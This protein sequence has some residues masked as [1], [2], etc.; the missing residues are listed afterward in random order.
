MSCAPRVILI[1]PSPATRDVLARRLRAQGFDVD[2]TGDPAA[3]ADMALCAPPKAVIADLWMGGVSGVQL[4]RL[5]RA[6]PAT[7]EIAVLLRGDTDEPR[8]RFWA[9]RAGADVYLLKRHTDE[10]VRVLARAVEGVKDAAEDS[11]ARCSGVSGDIRDRIARQ[12]DDALFDSVIASE[13][14]ALATCGAFDRM[15]DRLVQLLSQVAR[16]RWVAVS[17]QGPARLAV[18]HHPSAAADVD[19]EVRAALGPAPEGAPLRIEDE[20]A[21]DGPAAAPA[22]VEDIPFGR[23]CVG[24]V[25]MSP[26]AARDVDATRALLALVAR[27]LGGPIRMASLVEESQRLASL[28]ALTGIMNRRSFGATMARELERTRRYGHPLTLA[29]LDVDR[30]K[31]INDQHGHVAGDEVLTSLGALLSSSAVRR[32]D[33][34]ARWGGE[35]FVVA[36]LSTPEDGAIIA[37][38]RLRAAIAAMTVLN[39]GGQRIPV[40]ASIGLAAARPDDTLVSLV[41]RAD[42]AMYE[43]KS[44]GRNRVTVSREPKGEARAPGV[45]R[46]VK[47]A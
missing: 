9:D 47:V 22:I 2:E 19:D 24:R 23:A 36:F 29:L 8:N 17:T 28:D 3:G 34:V 11:S 4:C 1:D 25:A 6:E 35:E 18:H 10:L 39:G 26:C 32:T 38:E 7:A 14:R 43:S 40:T 30:F 41:A 13:V 37:A 27:E 31:D 5:L 33:L 46:F 12:L 42:V 15:F 44:Q 20:D 21:L 16:Y 45:P